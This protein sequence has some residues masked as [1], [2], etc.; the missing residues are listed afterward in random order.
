MQVS[1]P[2][3]HFLS[4]IKEFGNYS[5]SIVLDAACGIGAL[6]IHELS[7][8][9]GD[10]LTINNLDYESKGTL[11]EKVRHALKVNDTFSG[12]ATHL[13]SFLPA[14]SVGVNT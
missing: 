3:I 4:Q 12:E 7:T 8:H 6:K 11:N 9:L 2:S 1:H 13:I 5:S 10:S 14:F